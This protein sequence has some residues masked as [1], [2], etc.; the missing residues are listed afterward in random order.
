MSQECI[1]RACFTSIALHPISRNSRIYSLSYLPVLNILVAI[2]IDS[3]D[4]SKKR[5]REI[6]YRARIEY[7]A[8]LVARKQF[9]TPKE[10]SDFHVATYIPQTA[11]AS[12]RFFYFL[13]IVVAFCVAEYGFVGMVHFLML[14]SKHDYRMIR[15]LVIIYVCVG[16]IFNAYVMSVGLI[17][18]FKRYDKRFHQL[19]LLGGESHHLCHDFIEKIVRFLEVVVKMFHGILGFNAERTV[20]QNMVDVTEEFL[21]TNEGK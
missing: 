10:C 5:S 17:S 13:V 6:F 7:A 14:E 20:N 2:I 15:S 1:F 9:L 19:K 12:L 16:S 4:T 21:I 18:L 8:H 3:Y 11:R